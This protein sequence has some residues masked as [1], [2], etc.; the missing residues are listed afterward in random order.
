[1]DLISGYSAVSINL[2][3]EQVLEIQQIKTSKKKFPMVSN[4]LLC[5]LDLLA[6]RERSK[7]ESERRVEKS[8]SDVTI[9]HLGTGTI[10]CTAKQ[11]R[12]VLG[13]NSV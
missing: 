5:L 8:A 9:S 7:S 13:K 2:K 1:M 10:L 3:D 6:S 12:S 4:F 11:Q